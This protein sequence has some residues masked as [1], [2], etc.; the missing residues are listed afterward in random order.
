MRTPSSHRPGLAAPRILAHRRRPAP[1][2]RP[3]PWSA[4]GAPVGSEGGRGDLPEYDVRRGVPGVGQAGYA[5]TTAHLG[6]AGLADSAATYA[7]NALNHSTEYAPREMAQA[8]V[9]FSRA[10][11]ELAR[12]EGRNGSRVGSAPVTE[13]ATRSTL[14]GSRRPAAGCEHVP[15]RAVWCPGAGDRRATGRRSRRT[16]TTRCGTPARSRLWWCG[17]R[18]TSK[19]RFVARFPWRE[20]AAGV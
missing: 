19:S 4:R 6:A 17:G 11:A 8:G 14:G 12:A 3:P 10:V 15:G 16:P 5:P 1:V 13:R 7:Q 20:S 9:D 2:V 18:S